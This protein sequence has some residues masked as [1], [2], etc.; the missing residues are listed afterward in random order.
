MLVAFCASLAWLWGYGLERPT[1]AAIR[2]CFEFFS[3]AAAISP[4]TFLEDPS[5]APVPGLLSLRLRCRQCP[6][7]YSGAPCFES[8]LCL[9]SMVCSAAALPAGRVLLR[10]ASPVLLLAT[11]P[12][13]AS[14]KPAS[15]APMSAWPL[16]GVLPRRTEPACGLVGP[17]VIAYR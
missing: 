4:E 7:Y 2:L 1:E 9:S 6:S 11:E 13:A 3:K 15:E 5:V 8:R 17:G 16:C 14:P 12:P 10:S